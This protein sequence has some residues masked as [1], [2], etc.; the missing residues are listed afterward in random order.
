MEPG[1]L[2]KREPAEPNGQG[3]SDGRKLV[4]GHR[5]DLAGL[6]QVRQQT[7]VDVQI[8]F[9]LSAVADI[10]ALGQH[11]PHFWSQTKRVRKR[12]EHHVSVRGTIAGPA[13]RGK[14][15]R[16]RGVVGEV[17]PALQ[18]VRSVLRIGESRAARL[19]EPGKLLRVR[20]LLAERLAWP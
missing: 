9:V 19:L 3:G 15:Q 10:M 7:L 17:E 18:G 6:D 16:V 13:Q 4:E 14:A 8:A 20:G 5:H 11:A 2:L 1:Q 12:L